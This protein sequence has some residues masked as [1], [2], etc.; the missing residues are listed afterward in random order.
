MSRGCEKSSRLLNGLSL[1]RTPYRVTRT[2]GCARRIACTAAHS[3]NV[4]FTKSVPLPVSRTSRTKAWST[5]LECSKA[6]G[7]GAIFKARAYAAKACGLSTPL[8]IL[9]YSARVSS[10][11]YGRSDVRNSGRPRA[12]HRTCRRLHSPCSAS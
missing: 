1:S 11:R 12:R 5:S 7:A 10:S 2:R 8:W 6:S 3:T 9:L 4:L